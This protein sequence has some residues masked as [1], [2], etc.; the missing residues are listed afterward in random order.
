MTEDVSSW[1]WALSGNIGGMA[2][3]ILE[4]FIPFFFFFFFLFLL[5][6][7]FQGV[8]CSSLGHCSHSSSMLV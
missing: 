6:T 8:C 7:F 2:G 4:I 1:I 5:L 3:V